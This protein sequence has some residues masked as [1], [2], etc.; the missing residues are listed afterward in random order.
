MSKQELV[1]FFQGLLQ[2]RQANLVIKHAR[3]FQCCLS[4]MQVAL[5]AR[6]HLQEKLLHIAVLN[7][8]PMYRSKE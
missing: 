6:A 8:Q 3:R 2:Q 4:I 5:H 1:H 7:E